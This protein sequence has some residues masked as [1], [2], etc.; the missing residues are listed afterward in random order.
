MSPGQRKYIERRIVD[1]DQRAHWLRVAVMA[2]WAQDWH[3]EDL[4]ELET[5]IAA[6]RAR[7]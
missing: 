3:R 5:K 6:L 1:L 7:L 2:A 4:N